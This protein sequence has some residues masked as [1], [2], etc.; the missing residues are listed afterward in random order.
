MAGE[1]SQQSSDE[2]LDV[3]AI[4]F[5]VSLD[6]DF[7]GQSASEIALLGDFGEVSLTYVKV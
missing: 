3:Q 2:S 1:A 7:H 6:M 4:V 5:L